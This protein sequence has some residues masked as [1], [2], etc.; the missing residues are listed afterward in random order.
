M[1][2]YLGKEWLLGRFMQISQGQGYSILS[3][4]EDVKSFG[5]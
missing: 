4:L 3:V 5:R 1:D 2:K